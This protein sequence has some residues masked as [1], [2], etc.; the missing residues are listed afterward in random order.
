M[1]GHSLCGL[2]RGCCHNGAKTL[3]IRSIERTTPAW[4]LTPRAVRCPYLTDPPH[5]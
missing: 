4:M 3:A 2:F 1:T 5:H